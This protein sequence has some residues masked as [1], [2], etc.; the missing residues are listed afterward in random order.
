MSRR[1]EREQS[2]AI[3]GELPADGIGQGLN[4]A[5]DALRPGADAMKAALDAPYSF[6]GIHRSVARRDCDMVMRYSWARVKEGRSIPGILEG[7]N[8]VLIRGENV[9]DLSWHC[10]GVS[11]RK[12]DDTFVVPVDAFEWM[13]A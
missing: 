2:Q 12:G 1:K 8:R 11:V 6:E 3:G 10:Q 13:K 9:D 4:V 7:K 5:V